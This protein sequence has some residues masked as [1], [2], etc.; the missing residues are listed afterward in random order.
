MPIFALVI[1]AKM[2]PSKGVA[3]NLPDRCLD[4]MKNAGTPRS[5]MRAS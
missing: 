2:E 4:K 5:K 3:A 1:G